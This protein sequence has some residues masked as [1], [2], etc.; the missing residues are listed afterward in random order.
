[1]ES[2][3]DK[4]L[5][6]RKTKLRWWIEKD[7][8]PYSARFDPQHSIEWVRNSHEDLKA[9]EKRET[10]VSLA[11]RIV[12]LRGH[13]KTSFADLK[14]RTERIQIYA[15]ED[16]LKKRYP[17][18]QKLDIGDI[19]GVKGKV[20]KTKSG[21]LTVETFDFLLLAKSLRPLPEKWHGLQDVELRYRKRY[22]DLIA[23]PGVRDIFLQRGAII[24]TVRNFL[25]ERGFLEVETP[26]MQPLPGGATARPFRTHHRALNE[27]LYLRI[28]PELYLK[29]LIV[30]GMEK[31]Y[32]LN[33][34]FR[35]EGIDRLHNPEFTMLEVYSAYDGYE[36]MMKL[37]EELIQWVAKQIKGTLEISYQKE[38]IHLSSPWKRMTFIQALKEIGNL[39]MNLKNE[40]EVRAAASEVGL[41]VEGLTGAQILEHLLDHQVVPKLVQPTFIVDYPVA[42]SPLAKR[43]KEDPSLVERFEVFMGRQE[44]GN[45]YSELNDP[46][47]QRARFAK[48]EAGK[49]SMDEDFLEALEYGMPPTGGLGIGIDRLVMLLTDS[50]SIRQ[51]ILF[52]QLKSKSSEEG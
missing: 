24:N 15:R 50:V 34:N 32:E 47:E 36:E 22:L 14:D 30:G 49:G 52:P 4:L 18:F 10:K 29:K 19:I 41:N 35:N 3:K 37:T 45:A 6:E 43:K 13:G 31:V 26:M 48:T 17:L 51:V 42:T 38:R 20:F 21:E 39:E 16:R 2:S 23:N 9:G 8:D 33:R 11:G 5:E 25:N 7:E 12:A 46:I 28:A 1:M 27:D 40:V 44:I